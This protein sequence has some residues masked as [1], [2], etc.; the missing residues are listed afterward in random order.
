MGPVQFSFAESRAHIRRRKAWANRL[1]GLEKIFARAS[2]IA[3]EL[4]Y[5]GNEADRKWEEGDEISV[6][7]FIALLWNKAP[8]MR[9]MSI[10]K[11]RKQ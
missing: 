2:L 9:A 11:K 8:A 6:L 5:V 1:I 3:G 10:M 7:E 4:S